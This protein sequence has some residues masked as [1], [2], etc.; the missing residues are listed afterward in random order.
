MALTDLTMTISGPRLVWPAQKRETECSYAL[1]S[2]LQV[3]PTQV[4]MFAA[5]RML[6]HAVVDLEAGADVLVCDRLE[7]ITPE[8]ARPLLANEPATHPRTGE[9]LLMVRY[10]PIGGFVPLGALLEDGRPHPHAGT[11]FALVTVIGYP[12]A[13][14]QQ[15]PAEAQAGTHRYNEL[16]QLRFDGR[17][18]TIEH[19][20]IFKQP[21][22]DGYHIHNRPLGAAIADG[23]YLVMGLVCERP[24][25][26]PRSGLSRW[27][28]GPAGWQPTEFV[29]VTGPDR[30]FEP[31][32]VRDTDGSLLMCVRSRDALKPPFPVPDDRP[33]VNAGNV[34]LYRSTNGGQSWTQLIDQPFVRAPSPIAVL[35]HASGEPFLAGNPYVRPALDKQG[36]VIQ[37]TRQRQTLSFWPLSSNRTDLGEKVDVLDGVTRFGPPRKLTEG[38]HANMWLIDHPIGGPFRM[39]D[40]NWHTLVSF[41]LT[42]V[43]V[44]AQGAPPPEHGGIW[45][46]EVGP[47]ASAASPPWRFD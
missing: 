29:P 5:L 20:E 42:D 33:L 21:L 39:S 13:L 10:I 34:R 14:D 47:A 6:G 3:S 27:R 31:T 28:R 43:S 40:G 9:P 32:V 8:R 24:E 45:V 1:G 35:R 23:E 26:L 12:A 11:G 46:E 15:T 16:H 18:L 7:D 37:E 22:G 41:R 17:D 38:A 2:M 19:T 30:A 4:A 25:E 44:N 36:R